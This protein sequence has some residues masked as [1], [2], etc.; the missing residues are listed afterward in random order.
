MDSQGVLQSVELNRIDDSVSGVGDIYLRQRNVVSCGIRKDNS[1]TKYMGLRRDFEQAGE[2]QLEFSVESI[3]IEGKNQT[4]DLSKNEPL[5]SIA[6]NL[7]SMIVY[8][9]RQVNRQIIPIRS[10]I[11]DFRFMF[12]VHLPGLKARYMPQY[13]EYWFFSKA[14]GSFRFRFGV[15]VVLD[16]QTFMQV[17]DE[18]SVL[19]GLLNWEIIRDG[20]DLIYIKTPG[21]NWGRYQLP[22][23]VGVDKATIFSTTAD[24]MVDNFEADWDTNRN[25]VTGSNVADASHVDNDAVSVKSV[26]P[27]I[28][29][30]FFYFDVSGESGTVSSVNFSIY[31]Y[32]NAGSEYSVQL[33]TQGASLATTDFDSF[34]GNT[35]GQSS[36][37]AINQHNPV[38]LNAQGISDLQVQIG[39]GT[40][41]ACCRE[42]TY[43]YSNGGWGNVACGV[44]FADEELTTKDPYLE[45]TYAAAG[46]IVPQAMHH[47]RQ[48]RV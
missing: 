35:Y 9:N 27:K 33:G 26:G 46:G 48:Q 17:E 18:D 47:Y 38:T 39:S 21:P 1:L 20:D 41:K 28:S 30:T 32:V 15:P 10:D 13:D 29:R 11:Q 36:S 4:I 24:G 34:S 40:F 31:G 45:I 6:T 37:F 22:A 8:H 42:Y 25:A 12:R 7:G 44:T 5:N 23:L 14:D 2:C 19:P 43:D 3:E 16:L